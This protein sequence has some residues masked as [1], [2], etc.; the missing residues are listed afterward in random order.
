MSVFCP[1]TSTLSSSK[2][3]KAPVGSSNM[4][5]LKIWKARSWANIWSACFVCFFFFSSCF[6]ETK[7]YQLLKQSVTQE[8][9]WQNAQKEEEENG[10]DLKPSGN[11]STYLRNPKQWSHTMVIL[12]FP[13]CWKKY[14]REYLYC[15]FNACKHSNWSWVMWGCNIYTMINSMTRTRRLLNFWMFFLSIYKLIRNWWKKKLLVKNYLLLS[16]YL[17]V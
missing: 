2:L 9:Q 13:R 1:S 14:C 8:I 10:S 3:S 11:W 5:A 16:V 6:L 12:E 7:A 17:T 4:E 15:L